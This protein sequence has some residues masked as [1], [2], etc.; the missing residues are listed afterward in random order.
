LIYDDLLKEV[1][2]QLHSIRTDTKNR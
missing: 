2:P 1:K